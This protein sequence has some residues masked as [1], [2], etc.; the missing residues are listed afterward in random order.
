MIS[1]KHKIVEGK[2]Y[3]KGKKL[4][5]LG[6]LRGAFPIMEE[7]RRLGI[8][9][10]NG[11]AVKVERR[12]GIDI[13]HRLDYLQIRIY[14]KAEAHMAPASSLQ[15]DLGLPLQS[16]SL[17]F[18]TLYSGQSSTAPSDQEKLFPPRPASFTTHAR[19]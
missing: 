6:K 13:L 8:R 18:Q 1:S 9:R 16:Q 19:Q 7:E 12:S 5:W 15:R 17:P 4:F 14:R 10:R 3:L 2:K 11:K